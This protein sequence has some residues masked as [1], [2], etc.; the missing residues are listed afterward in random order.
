MRQ[1]AELQVA[2]NEKVW[3]STKRAW[4]DYKLTMRTHTSAKKETILP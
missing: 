1:G 2:R 4:D 3:N